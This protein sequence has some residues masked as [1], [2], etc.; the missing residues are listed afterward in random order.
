MGPCRFP[1]PTPRKLGLQRRERLSSEWVGSRQV[2]LGLLP[3]PRLHQPSLR[4][5]FLT[6]G[7]TSPL[8]RSLGLCPRAH[9]SNSFD[10]ALAVQ[11][12]SVQALSRVRLFVTPWTAAC[13]A[14]LSITNSQSLLKFMSTESV[15]PSSHLT[16][17]RPLLFPPSIFPSIRV[18][19]SESVLP[20][21]VAKVLEFQ[22]QHQ[23]FQ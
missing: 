5:G 1:R 13:Q 7:Q 18:F 16:L 8:Q 17:C 11:F 10:S 12:S 3:S 23:S 4:G 14:S 9:L 15:M 22:L 21:Q 2:L 20:H 19:S 6:P